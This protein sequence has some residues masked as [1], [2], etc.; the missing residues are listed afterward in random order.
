MK[1]HLTN[2][3][4]QCVAIHP[5]TG[6]AIFIKRGVMGFYDMPSDL[7]EGAVKLYNAIHGITPRQREAMLAGS[8]FGWDVPGADPDNPA[9]DR[10]KDND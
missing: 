10:L 9:Y 7:D 3:P 8:M 5:S 1:R 6:K 2:L 4:D